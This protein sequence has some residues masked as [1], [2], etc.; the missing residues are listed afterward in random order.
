MNAN[1]AA[2]TD[3]SAF[4]DEPREVDDWAQHGINA[5]P[6]IAITLVAMIVVFRIK[7]D[8]I[9]PIQVRSEVVLG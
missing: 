2:E 3:V 7:L 6:R 9:V 4:A 5:D 8:M 1:G